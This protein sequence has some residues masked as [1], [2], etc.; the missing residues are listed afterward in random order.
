M[1]ELHPWFIA[2]ATFF[3]VATG[4]GTLI[5]NI[6]LFNLWLNCVQDLQCL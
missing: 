5:V 4:D 1:V 6:T 2:R 3:D